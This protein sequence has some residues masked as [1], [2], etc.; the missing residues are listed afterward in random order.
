MGKERREEKG[1]GGITTGLPAKKCSVPVS[2]VLGVSAYP[3]PRPAVRLQ[4]YRRMDIETEEMC[5]GRLILL[6][7]ID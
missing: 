2:V 4:R 6:P 7:S 5:R 1:V 3:P